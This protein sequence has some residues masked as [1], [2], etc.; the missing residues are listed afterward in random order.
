MGDKTT[1][2]VFVGGAAVGWLDSRVRGSVGF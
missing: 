1:S 2:S